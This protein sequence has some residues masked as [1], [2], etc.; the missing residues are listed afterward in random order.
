MNRREMW[1]PPDS[2]SGQYAD[3]ADGVRMYMADGRSTV[4]VPKPARLTFLGESGLASFGPPWPDR[5]MLQVY[6]CTALAP[7]V[8][9]P[10]IY[11]WLVAAD[12][13]DGYVSGPAEI[14]YVIGEESWLAFAPR[15]VAPWQADYS[16]RRGTWEYMETLWPRPRHQA[17]VDQSDQT[18]GQ[19]A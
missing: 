16:V 9:R 15:S 3:H 14:C 2:A 8:D 1:R 11:R 13:D 12:D 18:R 4:F 5:W 10:F 7:Y 6:P 19:A 17:L